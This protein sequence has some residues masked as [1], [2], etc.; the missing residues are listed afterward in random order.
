[1]KDITIYGQ[2]AFRKPNRQDKKR[3]TERDIRVKTLN[4]QSKERILKAEREKVKVTY[5]G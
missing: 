5:K 4:L 1:L 2:K 3:I